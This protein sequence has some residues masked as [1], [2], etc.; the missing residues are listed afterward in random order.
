MLDPYSAFLE[1]VGKCMDH[2]DL[3]LLQVCSNKILLQRVKKKPV[4]VTYFLIFFVL[5]DLNLFLRIPFKIQVG[6]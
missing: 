5:K 4:F 2:P 3:L 6:L 1:A